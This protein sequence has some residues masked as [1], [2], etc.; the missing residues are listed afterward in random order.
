M[1]SSSTG[2]YTTPHA[3]WGV[4]FWAITHSR[5]GTEDCLFAFQ[6]PIRFWRWQRY[7]RLEFQFPLTIHIPPYLIAE[8]GEQVLGAEHWDEEVISEEES[9]C[10]A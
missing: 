9:D 2:F 1:T 10:N 4:F 7:R 5:F 8:Y 6:S 3:N